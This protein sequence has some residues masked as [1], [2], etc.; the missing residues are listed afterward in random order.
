MPGVSPVPGE[1]FVAAVAAEGHGH[2]L[3]RVAADQG[4]RQQRTVGEG[5]AEVVQYGLDGVE[6]VLEGQ[7]K[8]VVSRAEVAGDEFGVA[9]SRRIAGDRHNRC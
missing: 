5:L 8:R 2:M 7:A 9:A 4:G 3:T 6:N 1:E